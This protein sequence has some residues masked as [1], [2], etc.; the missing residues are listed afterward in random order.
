MAATFLSVPKVREKVLLL[1]V[2]MKKQELFH[3]PQNPL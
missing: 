2:A 3:H 1:E